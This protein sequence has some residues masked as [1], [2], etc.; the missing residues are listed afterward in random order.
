MAT[1]ITLVCARFSWLVELKQHRAASGH[2]AR[3]GR[4]PKD[5]LRLQGAPSAEHIEL[6]IGNE[7]GVS[8]ESNCSQETMQPPDSGFRIEQ[9]QRQRRVAV[10]EK[11]GID[12]ESIV[13]QDCVAIDVLDVGLNPEPHE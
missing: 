1:P 12:K 7:L 10:Y 5:L 3:D 13:L 4:L 11:R 6:R 2:Y 8:N 9:S